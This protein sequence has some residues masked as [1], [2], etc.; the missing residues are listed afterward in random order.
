MLNMQINTGKVEFVCAHSCAE[1]HR[2]CVLFLDKYHLTI[3]Y[4]LIN[5]GLGNFTGE[6]QNI[7]GEHQSVIL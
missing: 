5:M 1:K 2:T 3:G 7:R 4:I 6:Y